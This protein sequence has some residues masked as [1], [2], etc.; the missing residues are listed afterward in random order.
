MAGA[1]FFFFAIATV[2]ALVALRRYFV[3]RLRSHFWILLGAFVGLPPSLLGL[4]LLD[5]EF[6]PGIFVANLILLFPTVIG[7]CMIMYGE[8]L[9]TTVEKGYWETLR[10]RYGVVRVALGLVPRDAVNQVSSVVPRNFID[11]KRVLL[12]SLLALPVWYLASVVVTRCSEMPLTFF[13]C[14]YAIYFVLDIYGLSLRPE[15]KKTEG[16]RG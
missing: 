10:Q 6:T 13:L 5:A 14:F 4:K 1:Q 15:E 2:G 9:L 11:W 12:F 7:C 16:S 3:L 8:Y